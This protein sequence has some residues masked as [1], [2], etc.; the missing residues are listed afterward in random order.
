MS[1]L[2]RFASARRM[3]RSESVRWAAILT[4]A[5]FLLATGFV[6]LVAQ[7]SIFQTDGPIYHGLAYVL[8][9]EFR[10]DSVG[11]PYPLYS[12]FLALVYVFGG[13]YQ[14]VFLVQGLF[15]GLTAGLSYWL[16]RLIAGH[17]AGVFAALLVMF[18]VS[19]LGNV[20]LI[21]TENLQAPLLMLALIL[22]LYAIDEGKVRFHAVA[23]LVW[24]L[25][26]LVK[27]ATLFWP[28]VLLPVYVIAG[29]GRG[30]LIRWLFLVLAFLLIL[31]PWIVRNQFSAG[32]TTT[33]Q[34]Y[35]PLLLHVI[36]EGEVKH[37]LSN[38]M[39]KLFAVYDEMEAQGIEQGS[40]QFELNTL[41]LLRERIARS[42]TAYA[43]YV[44]EKFSRFW[45]EPSSDWPYSVYNSI[46]HYPRGFKT[47][48]GYAEY[49][50]LHAAL[51]LVSLVSL[52]LL[53]RQRPRG[54]L[55]LTAFVLYYGMLYTMT[56]LI[57]RYSGPVTP[58][59]LVG[60][61]VFPT[62]AA[63]AIKEMLAKLRVSSNVLL[64]GIAIMLFVGIAAQ[65]FLQS[66]KYVKEGSFETE[67]AVSAWRYE[68]AV[69]HSVAP[70]VVDPHWSQDGFRAALLRIDPP[71]REIEARI[72]QDIPVWF[73]TKYRLKF[74]YL[75]TEQPQ[76]S[77]SFYVEVLEWDL[78]EEG[79]TRLGKEFQPVVS[80]TWMEQEYEIEV[81]D[82]A[83]SITIVFGLLN[84]PSAVLIDNVRLELAEPVW[85]IV[86][87]PYLLANPGGIEQSDFL[88]L[89][90]WLE[91][92]PEEDRSR[93]LNNV[94]AARESGWRGD[95]GRLRVVVFGVGLVAIAAWSLLGVV[96]I[97]LRVVERIVRTR[98]L[99]QGLTGVM[100][101]VVLAQ[102]ATCYLVLFS[103]PI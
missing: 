52:S 8:A 91:S 53:Y 75:I 39:P 85:E 90:Q 43:G 9:Q 17:V 92:Q 103:H 50:R 1:I 16:A 82:S 36:D 10:Y 11:Y 83:R 59:V 98:L 29:R 77:A 73:S 30:L 27:P 95:E 47:V 15:L 32:S 100:A 70:L 40:L 89:S 60:A 88:P 37:D 102:V 72:V 19:L 33:G 31:S 71:M 49:A 25:L 69:G 21:L 99:E 5:A 42:P 6:T 61:A 24:G 23:G 80:S 45:A 14:A 67:Q 13:D 57:P 2:D 18:D 22:S 66:P 56:F 74:S 28:I 94:D 4:G 20:G 65:L 54:A 96:C 55:L 3:A 26:T 7:P 76:R 97:R 62:L 64:A 41:R 81:S 12:I 58:L 38:L 63:G 35:S 46:K 34:P 48:P 68:D 84:Q 86:E 44:W 93:L 78:V 51:A 87:R 101:L 79:W